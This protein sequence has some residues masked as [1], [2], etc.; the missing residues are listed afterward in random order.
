M[1]LPL[2]FY[3][4]WMGINS[5]FK[6]LRKNVDKHLGV[7]AAVTVLSV[8]LHVHTDPRQLASK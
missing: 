4:S 7:D 2:M 5:Y 3:D 8:A 6:N 1:L